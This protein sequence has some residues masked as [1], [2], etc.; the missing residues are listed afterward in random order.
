MKNFRVICS[1]ESRANI[2]WTEHFIFLLSPVFPWTRSELLAVYT[3][4][5]GPA[6]AR[7]AL[8]GVGAGAGRGHDVREVNG[9]PGTVH[10]VILVLDDV[11]AQIRSSWGFARDVIA[12]LT[13]APVR[14]R[15]LVSHISPDLTQLPG[16]QQNESR[17]HCFGL[18][19]FQINNGETWSW[20]ITV[21]VWYIF[22]E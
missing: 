8:K 6:L 11:I 18:S 2:R 9:H 16:Q 3:S 4:P 19:W 17:E 13:V 7:A 20:N 10:H 14:D 15:G 5:H 22:C 12:Q 1:K 21:K